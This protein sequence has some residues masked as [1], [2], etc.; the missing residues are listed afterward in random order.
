MSRKG[1]VLYHPEAVRRLVD[2]MRADLHAQHFAHLC[3]LADL[4]RE[5]D[6]MRAEL[7]QLR[8]LRATVRARHQ[9]EAEL[10]DLHR[11]RSLAQAWTA[12][13]DPTAPLQ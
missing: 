5:V 4:K 2:S 10:A 11:Q 9:V 6:A 7:A 12:P 13:R 3:E 1:R 8:E